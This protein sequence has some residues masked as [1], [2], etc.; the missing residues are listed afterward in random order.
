MKT[1]CNPKRFRKYHDKLDTHRTSKSLVA[2]PDCS[3]DL[4]RIVSGNGSFTAMRKSP[5][6]FFPSPPP[7]VIRERTYH[8]P[9]K[10]RINPRH[11][12]RLRNHHCHISL[13]HSHHRLHT[14]RIRHRIRR[15]LSLAIWIFQKSATLVSRHE[16][17]LARL[18]RGRRKNGG[19]RAEG[20]AT[21][22]RALFAESTGVLLLRCRGH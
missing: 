1:D 5:L 18:E 14:C 9:S 7:D 11:N 6:A 8:K 22:K 13:H 19:V 20:H 17:I 3:I 12:Q 16:V 4:K 2:T 10:E 15:R 21:H